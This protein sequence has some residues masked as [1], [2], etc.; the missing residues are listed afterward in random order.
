[1][2]NKPISITNV[3]DNQNLPK[4]RKKITIERDEDYNLKSTIEFEDPARSC[5]LQEKSMQA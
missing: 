2:L 4:E 3:E 1:M 5:V